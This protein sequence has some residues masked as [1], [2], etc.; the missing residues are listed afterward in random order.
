MRDIFEQEENKIV[1]ASYE[2]YTET[3]VAGGAVHGDGKSPR[4]TVRNSAGPTNDTITSLNLGKYE[5]QKSKR[6]RNS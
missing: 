4:E 3:S 6:E 2:D 1:A 5:S